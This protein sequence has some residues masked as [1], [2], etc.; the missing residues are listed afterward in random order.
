MS[1]I[2]KIIAFPITYCCRK[3]SD[4]KFRNLNMQNTKRWVPTFKRAK[5]VSVYDGDTVNIVAF[6]NNKPYKFR[7]RIAR[8]DAPEMK[9]DAHKS[10]RKRDFELR[11]AKRSQKILSDLVLH[12]M[13]NIVNP[14]NE[15]WGRI[16]CDFRLDGDDELISDKMLKSGYA[17]PYDGGKKIDWN[18]EKKLTESGNISRFQI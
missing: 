3:V 17:I 7:C 16:L 8:I 10:K 4:R 11:A 12:N 15:K 5:V 1:C 13:V 2:I 6:I 18:W 14:K 9:P